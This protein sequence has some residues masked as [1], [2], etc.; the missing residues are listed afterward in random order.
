M[1]D[2]AIIDT[3]NWRELGENK[4]G[5]KILGKV[6]TGYLD[7][8]IG[9]FKYPLSDS[10]DPIAAN[11]FIASHL[12]LKLD[13]PVMKTFFKEFEGKKGI[14]IHMAYGEPNMWQHFPYKNDVERTLNDYESLGK[15][16]V[17]D[18]F[19]YNTD[20]K[21]DN[22]LYSRIGKRKYD[23]YLIDHALSLYGGSLQPNDYN[24]FN[25]GQM[26]QMSEFRNLF[27]KG[28]GFF[29]PHID[30][31]LKIDDVFI[32]DLV[33][34]IPQDYLTEGQKNSTKDLLIKRR[35][36]LYNK[37]EEFCKNIQW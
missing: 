34:K 23:Y 11:E 12:A 3:N 21:S 32:I 4:P 17:F 16:V 36:L 20:R 13:L 14:L 6:P 1:P 22:F 18:V 10:V 19:I 29:K 15:V 28:L 9:Y 2:D 33:N 31:I 37:F 7:T 25:F 8:G 26:V 30:E 5:V 35:D 27:N 24:A